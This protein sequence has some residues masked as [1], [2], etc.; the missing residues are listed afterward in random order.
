MPALG[1]TQYDRAG[2]TAIA[3]ALVEAFQPVMNIRISRK[4]LYNS[5]ANQS[6]WLT[7]YTGFLVSQDLSVPYL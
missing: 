5:D 1:A 4:D 3:T 6:G 7:N 2:R